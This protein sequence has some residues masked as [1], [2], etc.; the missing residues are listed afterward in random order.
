MTI[1]VTMMIQKIG[2]KKAIQKEN[3]PSQAKGPVIKNGTNGVG[4]TQ[5]ATH[6]AR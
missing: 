6:R 5:K 4:D 3:K 1:N 2:P